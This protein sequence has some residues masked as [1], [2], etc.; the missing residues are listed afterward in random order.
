MAIYFC[1][2]SVVSAGG[3]RS[4]VASAA[5]QADEK[6]KRDLDGKT[7][8]FQG[9]HGDTLGPTGILLPKNAPEK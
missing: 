5:Y 9:R 1:R 4:A 6:I 7:R 2:M 8:N 3:K